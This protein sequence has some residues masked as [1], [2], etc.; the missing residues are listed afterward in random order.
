MASVGCPGCGA[1][2]EVPPE[3][4]GR[5]GRCNTCGQRIRLA[6]P[7]AEL[8]DP[9]P[10]LPQLDDLGELE[11]VGDLLAPDTSKTAARRPLAPVTAPPVEAPKRAKRAVAPR[12]SGLPKWLVAVVALIGLLGGSASGALMVKYLLPA[13]AP[14]PE[15]ARPDDAPAP[16]PGPTPARPEPK[17]PEPTPPPPTP[18]PEPKPQ[19]PDPKPA[20]VLAGPRAEIKLTG[21]V[22]A[23]HASGERFVVFQT[24][25]GPLAVYDLTIGR[26]FFTVNGANPDD[27]V[28]V[29]RS[30]LYLGRAKDSQI[31]KFDLA[32]GKADGQATFGGA[33]ASLRH[34]A[35]GSAS[36]GPLLIAM[37]VNESAYSIR[38]LD[39]ENFAL[40]NYPIDDP[41][42]PR[43]QTF[44]LNETSVPRFVAVSGDGRAVMLGNR[45]YTRADNRFV[46]GLLANTGSAQHL[47]T[48]D[49]RGF[50]GT[51]L[52]DDA[53]IPIEAGLPPGVSRRYLPASGGPFVVSAEYRV[54]DPG[55]VKLQLHMGA[56]PNPLGPLPGGDEVAAW[57]RADAG[58][59]SKLHQRVA[60]VSDPPRLILC[61]PNS[62]TASAYPINLSTLLA[63]AGHDVCFTSTAAAEAYV[64]E[65]YSYRATTVS[66]R[67]PVAFALEAGPPGM[68]VARDGVL[69]W[70][71]PTAERLSH[72]VT[73]TA[74]AG[75]KSVTQTFRL[76]VVQRPKGK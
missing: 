3:L 44:P 39:T 36:D 19:P 63:Q 27:L 31:A 52:Y 69:S 25:A 42:A 37:R 74:T 65:A 61:G 22:A 70:P 50:V 8:V 28:A 55:A 26:P 57:A 38:L 43:L 2:C 23:V 29:S 20:P 46:G 60:F 9:Q 1:T 35:I 11:P 24:V 33:A 18:E 59:V 34:L 13:E 40:I 75:G 64:G 49:A 32:T 30:K 5:T 45:Y 72:K 76:L 6:T 14:K 54:N 68:T 53:G 41:S 51:R 15:V 4:L 66:A 7:M 21:P 73:L 16:A 12:P 62:D 58:W 17:P 10:E 67:G 47:P 56:D 48:A 71:N